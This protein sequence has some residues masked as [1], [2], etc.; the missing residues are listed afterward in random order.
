MGTQVGEGQGFQRPEL[1]GIARREESLRPGA[2]HW[3][4]SVS[5][6][7]GSAS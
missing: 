1:K 2:G 7:P 6:I 4:P 3:A 5:Q